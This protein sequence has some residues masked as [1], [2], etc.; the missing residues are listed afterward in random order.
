M[1]QTDAECEELTRSIHADRERLAVLQQHLERLRLALD[2]QD[3]QP[4]SPT[5]ALA[6][7]V[8][9]LKEQI[10][11]LEQQI[12]LENARRSAVMRQFDEARLALAALRRP[13]LRQGQA[14]AVILKKLL[15][16]CIKRPL[17]GFWLALQRSS[18]WSE[19]I[20]RDQSLKNRF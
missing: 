1:E 10:A 2:F 15:A 16:R 14:H 5:P 4:P 20:P 12:A 13:S 17:Y 8:A 11:G 19:T 9:A 3:D 6:T 18:E 7:Q